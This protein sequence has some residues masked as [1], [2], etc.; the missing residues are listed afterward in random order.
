MERERAREREGEKERRTQHRSTFARTPALTLEHT[1][2]HTHI[3]TRP[4][5]THTHTHTHTTR[6]PAVVNFDY[7]FVMTLYDGM[8]FE[9]WHPRDVISKI[10]TY[11][12]ERLLMIKGLW[13]GSHKGKTTF[14]RKGQVPIDRMRAR[15]HK[16][17]ARGYAV[18]GPRPPIKWSAKFPPW[19]W[20][21]EGERRFAEEGH[22]DEYPDEEDH[23]FGF[24]D[25]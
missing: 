16:Y 23:R 19:R 10:G 14:R 7:S 18:V 9:V 12:P 25:Y 6:T 3:R 8:G 11:N 15:L 21:A 5:H 2:T 20:G 4:S 17:E 1:H 22:E 13:F 24:G